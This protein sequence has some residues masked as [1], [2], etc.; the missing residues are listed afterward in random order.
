MGKGI[1]GE[2]NGDDCRAVEHFTSDFCGLKWAQN[3]RMCE[4]CGLEQL[5]LSVGYTF[6]WRYAEEDC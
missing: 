3:L 6:F 1:G 2:G 5:R 4:A